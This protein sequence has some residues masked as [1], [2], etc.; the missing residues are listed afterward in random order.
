[1]QVP[2]R[3]RAVCVA[4]GMAMR[5][6]AFSDSVFLTRSSGYRSPSWHH[7]ASTIGGEAVDRVEAR[8]RF[9]CMNGCTT[10]YKCTVA[11]VGGSAADAMAALFHTYAAAAAFWC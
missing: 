9:R 5:Q 8:S 2:L 11:A 6:S 3:F 1:M 10:S 7:A 4:R